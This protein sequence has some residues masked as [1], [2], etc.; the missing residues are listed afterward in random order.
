MLHYPA[1]AGRAGACFALSA[2]PAL[3]RA[4]R[5]AKKRIEPG[6]C[7]RPYSPELLPHTRMHTCVMHSC[8][9]A[10]RLLRARCPRRAIPRY[11]RV[12]S[13][14][15]LEDAKAVRSSTD[16]EQAFLGGSAGSMRA[17][18]S[19]HHLREVL[20]GQGEVAAA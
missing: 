6:A 3:A 1:C 13:P 7:L 11:K 9:H 12:L 14:E 8:A 4:K 15:A 17:T 5:A 18:P 10:L 2:L 19:G 16:V 20:V